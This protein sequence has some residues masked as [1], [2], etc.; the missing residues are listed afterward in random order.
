V[1]E[2]IA[3]YLAVRYPKLFRIERS[4]E[5]SDDEKTAQ[6]STADN[7]D[8]FSGQ[9]TGRVKV[10][11]LLST[12]ERWDLDRDDPMLVAGLLQMDD[13]AIMVEGEVLVSFRKQE[14]RPLSLRPIISQVLT[15]NIIFKPATCALLVRR[16]FRCLMLFGRDRAEDMQGFG[17]LKTRLVFR[18]G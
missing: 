14:E 16:D 13:L 17:D 6:P 9:E 12:G 5:A 8:S 2:E 3:S 10:I 7:G 18:C 11:E 15:S 4:A 1:C